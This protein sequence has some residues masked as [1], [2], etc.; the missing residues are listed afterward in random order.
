MMV[1]PPH[2]KAA[3]KTTPIDGDLTFDDF[4]KADPEGE[5]IDLAGIEDD[6]FKVKLVHNARI[7]I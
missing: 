2:P 7:L 6:F 1:L 3:P 5:A 4:I